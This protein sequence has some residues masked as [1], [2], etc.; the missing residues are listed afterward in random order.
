MKFYFLLI[1]TIVSFKLSL[2][3]KYMQS[4][5]RIEY[6]YNQLHASIQS[7]FL[8]MLVNLAKFNKYKLKLKLPIPG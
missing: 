8:L 1:Y 5:L 6:S 4:T 7:K 2:F 3:V